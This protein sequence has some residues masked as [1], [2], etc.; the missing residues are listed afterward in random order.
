M[1]F[2]RLAPV[3]L[4]E[5]KKLDVKRGYSGEEFLDSPTPLLYLAGEQVDHTKTGRKLE[6]PLLFKC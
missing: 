3:V 2:F 5:D 1:V 6:L 4:L